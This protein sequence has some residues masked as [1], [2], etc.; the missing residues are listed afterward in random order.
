MKDTAYEAREMAD[1]RRTETAVDK[2]S[3]ADRKEAQAEFLES[4]KTRPDWV[5]EQI[6]WMLEGNYGYGPMLVARNCTKRMNR[7]ALWTQLV[8]V[9]NWQCPRAMAVAAWKKL[10]KREQ[11]VLQDQLEQVARDYDEAVANEE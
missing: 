6:G 7:P 1:A 8:A 10:S 5:A 11:A 2:Q 4:M 3:L 9:Y